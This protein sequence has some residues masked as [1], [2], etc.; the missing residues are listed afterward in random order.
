M[1]RTRI[2]TPLEKAEEAELSAD[3]IKKIRE[4]NQQID[5]ELNHN[6]GNLESFDELLTKMGVDLEFY[7]LATR[8][9]FKHPKVFLKR[10]PKDC[11]INGYCK[12][13]L[14]LMRSNMDIQYVLDAYA[15]IGYIVD[16]INKS[17]RG[18]SRLLRMCI[19]DCR[20]GNKSIVEQMKACSHILYNSTEI[21]AQEAAWCRLRIAMCSTSVAVEFIHSGPPESRQRILKGPAELKKLPPDSTDIYKKGTLDRYGV[22]SEELEDLCLAEFVANFTFCNKAGASLEDPEEEAPALVELDELIPEAEELENEETAGSTSM[23]QKRFKSFP[24]KDGSGIMRER[25]KPKVIR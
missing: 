5:N 15:C 2:L 13:I 19:D 25:K 23:G 6:S 1:D 3:I 8:K 20:K 4:F 21:S 14:L 22:R 12:K 16:Y 11:R 7:I 18:L 9:T 24:L 17:A 10:A